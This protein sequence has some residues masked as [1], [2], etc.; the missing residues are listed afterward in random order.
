MARLSDWALTEH[1]KNVCDLREAG[2]TWTE[3]DAAVEGD[4]ANLRKIYRKV[5]NRAAAQG[6]APEYDMVHPVPDGQKIK[7]I[8]TNYSRDGTVN[9]QWVKSMSDEKRQ[10][11]MLVERLESGS[12]NFKRF[13]P[14]K[15]PRHCDD[16]IMSMISITDFHLGMYA[17]EAETGDDWDCEIARDVFLQSVAEMIAG[18]PKSALGVLN[19]MGD[20]L[21][22]DGLLAIT[23]Q[24][25]HI[26][27]AD[28]RYSKLVDLTLSVMTEAIAL[29]L[30]KFGQ[31]HVI[32]AEGN[33]DIVGS[34]WLRK[35]LKHVFADEPRVTVDDSEFPY[36]AMLWGDSMI[37]V[38]HGHKMK[39]AQLPK[40][41][42]SEPRYRAMWGQ[43]KNTYIHTGHLH[44]ER[45]VED[46]GAIVEQHPTLAARDAYAARGG[47]VSMRGAKAIS[48]HKEQGEIGRIT[49]RPRS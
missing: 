21:H 31:V 26:L 27:D 17:W 7:G 23:P 8:S 44:H 2:A 13:R 6:Y 9:Q 19:Q 39:M 41:F 18:C 45:V 3:V 36:Y 38:H 42:A 43:A 15:P 40:L 14:S 29:M 37:A 32:Q 4:I 1:Q 25:G 49:V 34:I 47:W 46:G 12:L 30:K 10:V 35:H 22:W 24:S 16:D 33:H 28:T 11:E 48:Y 20:F 5:K